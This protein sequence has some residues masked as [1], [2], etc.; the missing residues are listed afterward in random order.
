MT[1]DIK[2]L[3]QCAVWRRDID[4]LPMTCNMANF[5]RDARTVKMGI[6]LHRQ[7]HH[8]RDGSVKSIRRVPI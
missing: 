5:G 4:T 8:H 2:T 7:Q 6:L 1:N 3:L